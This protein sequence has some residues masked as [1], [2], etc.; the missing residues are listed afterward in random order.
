LSLAVKYMD[1]NIPN[2]FW[3]ELKLRKL[4]R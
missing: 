1:E 2:N 4:I 3:E